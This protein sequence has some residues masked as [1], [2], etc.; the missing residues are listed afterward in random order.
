M[1]AFSARTGPGPGTDSPIRDLRRLRITLGA[2][3]GFSTITGLVL[4]ADPN[5]AA[6]LIGASHPGWVRIVGSALLPFAAGV[7]GVAGSRART[8][9][10]LAPVIIVADFAWVLGSARII[11]AAWFSPRGNAVVVLV[12]VVVAALG[13]RQLVHWRRARRSN[14]TVEGHQRTTAR[15]TA[16]QAMRRRR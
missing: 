13:W 1:N 14:F 10:G 11:A 5:G 4:L 3:A 15:T 9:L 16:P 8:L 2:N 7:A 6:G 12:A